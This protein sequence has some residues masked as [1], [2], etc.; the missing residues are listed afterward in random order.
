MNGMKYWL[1]MPE[2]A[3]WKVTARDGRL[4]D[5]IKTLRNHNTNDSVYM[6]TEVLTE[7]LTLTHAKNIVMAYRDSLKHDEDEVTT[8]VWD[9]DHNGEQ[10]TALRVTK[11]AN[12]AGYK[13][14]QITTRFAKTEADAFRDVIL[15]GKAFANR[16]NGP[17][18]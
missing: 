9:T 8:V 16:Y 5:A 17:R 11:L 13:L 3:E 4:V 14:E 12:G 2:N 1:D 10:S 15:M 6:R 7:V 18:A